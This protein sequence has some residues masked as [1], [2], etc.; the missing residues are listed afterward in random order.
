[1]KQ[2]EWNVSNSLRGRVDMKRAF[3]GLST[4]MLLGKRK[5][6]VA[7][8]CC[9]LQTQKNSRLKVPKRKYAFYT[10]KPRKGCFSFSSFFGQPRC[11]LSSYQMLI[12]VAFLGPFDSFFWLIEEI[13]TNPKLEEALSKKNDERRI[14]K[15]ACWR[16]RVRSA[17]PTSKCIF[18][19]TQKLFTPLF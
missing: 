16:E 15:S 2:K 5:G 7:A 11:S 6:C 1:M 3:G 9:C 19:K 13:D 10:R 18:G 14:L 8:Y 4:W 12:C 17:S